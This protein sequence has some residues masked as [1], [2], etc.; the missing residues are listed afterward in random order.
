MYSISPP[1][2]LSLPAYSSQAISTSLICLSFTLF[3]TDCK[4]LALQYVLGKIKTSPQCWKTCSGWQIS[5]SWE[6]LSRSEQTGKVCEG[7][8]QLAAKNCRISNKHS[9]RRDTQSLQKG[10]STKNWAVCLKGNSCLI[11]RVKEHG[12]K[13]FQQTGRKDNMK[14]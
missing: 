8:K 3:S 14:L 1:T 12:E 5:V 2:F 10:G 6:G 4:Y 9:E 13:N 7:S 11:L